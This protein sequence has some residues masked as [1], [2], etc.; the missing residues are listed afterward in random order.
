[1]HV[2]YFI[3]QS[4]HLKKCWIRPLPIPDHRRHWRMFRG[5]ELNRFAITLGSCRRTRSDYLRSFCREDLRQLLIINSQIIINLLKTFSE[6]VRTTNAQFI[7]H[8]V[9]K[10]KLALVGQMAMLIIH[11]IKNP[12]TIIRMQA[13]L[14]ERET[15]APGRCKSIVRNADHITSMANDL[16]DFSRDKVSLKLRQ[17]SPESWL[18]DLLSLLQPMVENRKINLQAEVLTTDLLPL[19]SDRMTR[20]VYNLCVNAIQAMHEGGSL[21]IRIWRDQRGFEI[22]I[23]DDGPGIP[24][25]IRDRLFDP[26]V[27][28]GKQ[29][30]TGLGTSIAKKIIEDHGGQ[31]SF[32]TQAGIGTTFRIRLPGLPSEATRE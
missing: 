3:G 15:G 22:A 6:R 9:R 18:D 27:T 29:G 4:R 26:F 32:E 24:E 2:C 11:D 13:E 16:L 5:N 31:I 17:I 23:I 21:T 1:M 19:D 14:V 25:D 8:V 7:E 28:S 12:L 30:G 20:A 10:E